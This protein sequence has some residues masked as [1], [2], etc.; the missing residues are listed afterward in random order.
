LAILR[1]RLR[2]GVAAGDIPKTADLAAMIGDRHRDELLAEF[3]S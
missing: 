1:A 3:C 2:Q